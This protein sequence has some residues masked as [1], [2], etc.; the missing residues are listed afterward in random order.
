MSDQ[1]REPDYLNQAK[2][3]KIYRVNQ[4]LLFCHLSKDGICSFQI[5]SVLSTILGQIGKLEK[6]MK[7][8]KETYK[9]LS[10][11]MAFLRL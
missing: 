5:E 4:F 7:E 10:D 3:H 8:T 11:G 6:Q 1:E 2:N 9:N